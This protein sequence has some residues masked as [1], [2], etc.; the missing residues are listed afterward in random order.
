MLCGLIVQLRMRRHRVRSL[1]SCLCVRW[2]RSEL[3]MMVLKDT[4]LFVRQTNRIPSV[5][6]SHKYAKVDH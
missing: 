4:S 2:D 5:M 1:W 6:K 3:E